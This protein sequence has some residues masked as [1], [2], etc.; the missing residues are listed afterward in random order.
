MTRIICIILMVGGFGVG[1]VY[2]WYVN[3]FTGSEIG[4]YAVLE[5]RGGALQVPEVQLSADDAPVRVFVDMV[6][7]PGY[8]PSDRGTSLTIAVGR[9]GHPVLS[10]GL[11]Y[12]ATSGSINND[13]PQ[14]GSPLRQSAGDIDPVIPG[15]YAFNVILGNVDGL[16]VSKIDLELRRTALPL[17]ETIVSA[18]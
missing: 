5:S 6:P 1:L 3:N 12:Q 18:G 8:V 10:K 13:R 11:S 16:Q 2:P 17:N 7:M 15:N 9:D 4:R 14:D